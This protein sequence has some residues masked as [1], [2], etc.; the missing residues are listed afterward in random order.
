LNNKFLRHFVLK[1]LKNFTVAH[2]LENDNESISPNILLISFGRHN[3]QDWKNSGSRNVD[4]ID[5]KFHPDYTN[6]EIADADLVTIKLMQRI[7]YTS[8]IRPVCSWMEKI[9]LNNI[10]GKSGFVNGWRYNEKSY[11]HSFKP[12]MYKLHTITYIETTNVSST[13]LVKEFKIHL[14]FFKND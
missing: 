1:L 6:S 12:R 5:Y 14:I 2:C 13:Y 4:V 11:C 7:N 9:D 3:L 10:V 8:S